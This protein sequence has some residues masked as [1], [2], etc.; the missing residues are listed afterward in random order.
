LKRAGFAA[1]GLLLAACPGPGPRK[2]T[3]ASAP[4]PRP[5][6]NGRSVLLLT[7][8]TLRADHL[9]AYGYS[10][11]T[12]PNIDALA[13]SGTLFER[14]Y[15]YWP[16]TRGSFVAM[17]TGRRASAS[18]YG[19]THPQLLD[20]NPTL[21]SALQGVG[22]ATS[23]SVDNPNVAAALGYAK[24]FAS[25]RE[26]WTEAD[27][28]TEMDKTEAITGD[29]VRF[30]AAA[31]PEKP[32]LLWLHYVNPHAPYS[33][34][35]PY[36]T[37]FLD[38]RAKGGK[39]LPVVAS[40][41]GG[42][43]RQWA[44]AGEDRL[45]Y[46]VAQYDGEIAAVDAHV[47][48]VMEALASSAV[49]DSTVVLLTSDHGESLGEHDYYFDHGEDVFDPSLRVPL[50]VRAPGAPAGRRSDTLASTLDVVPTLLDAV[51]VSYPPDLS[52]R[53]LLPAVT[54]EDRS[55]PERLYAQN[56][57][58]LSAVFDARFK[59]MATPEGEGRRLALYDR[60]SDAGETKDVSGTRPDEFRAFRRELELFQDRV[61]QEWVRM[62]RQLAGV[63]GGQKLDADACER[64][65]AMGYIVAECE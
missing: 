56:D 12:S 17:L 28:K 65:R 8:D 55:A 23:A 54:G 46:Y 33:P 4:P 35:A 58:N 42:I 38:G 13:R 48:K 60:G 30:L 57:R 51:K 21:A 15:T 53:S 27:L 20:L 31:R 41:R 40:F 7:I 19:K 2:E 47:G 1:L 24:G 18:G 34:P 59:V 39:S 29:A 32:F 14:A 9:G 43:P 37:A 11:P 44:V 26:T 5:G 50:I 52:G 25:Y 63:A 6:G 45:G 3:P 64:L 49:R 62:K 16:K 10:R 61:D 36:D 22:F